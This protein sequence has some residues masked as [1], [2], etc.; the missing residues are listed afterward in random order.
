MTLDR[1]SDRSPHAYEAIDKLIEGWAADASRSWAVLATVE[2]LLLG[3]T[4]SRDFGERAAGSAPGVFTFFGLLER[5]G[6]LT[7]AHFLSAASSDVGMMAW[8]FT[9]QGEALVLLAAGDEMPGDIEDL[10]A[11]IE[12]ILFV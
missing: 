7:G 10:V 9:L 6:L 3:G 8:S 4:G 11:G 2:G 5:N 1:R 12:R